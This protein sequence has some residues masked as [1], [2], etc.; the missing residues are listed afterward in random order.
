MRQAPVMTF[1]TALKILGQHEHPLLNK[2]DNLLGGLILAGGAVA[3]AGPAAAPVVAVA[4]AVWGWT[5]QKNEAVGLM[6]KLLAS[7]TRRRLG[8]SGYERAELLAAAHTILVASSAM[9]VFQEGLGQNSP[10]T[11]E[12]TKEE[13]HELLVAEFGHRVL[14]DLYDSGVP[15]PSGGSGFQENRHDVHEWLTILVNR[16]IDYYYRVDSLRGTGGW[17]Q[18]SA[19]ILRA[20]LTKSAEKRYESRYYELAAKIPEFAMWALLGRHD[21]HQAEL[22]DL[23]QEVLAALDG[24]SAALSRLEALLNV[25]AGDTNRAELELVHIVRRSALA[26]LDRPIVPHGTAAFAHHQKIVFPTLREIYIEPRYRWTRYGERSR[27][28]DEHWWQE[29]P[30]FADL[31]LRLAAYFASPDAARRPLLVLGH[32]GAGKSLLTKVLAARLPLV[33]FTAVRVPLRHVPAGAPIYLQVQEALNQ[34]THG[35]VAWHALTEQSAGTVRV[36]LLDGLDELLQAAEQSR[37]S[38]SRRGRRVPTRRGGT[39]AAGRGAGD[40]TDDRGRQ[41]RRAGGCERRQTRGIR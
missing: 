12:L 28:S 36:I 18:L 8:L 3:A 17:Q 24:Q 25:L 7:A 23:H 9:E 32:P 2:L 35:R 10:R 13:E 16:L 21:E 40:V 30:V 27:I 33:T 19:E 38:F 4:A 20:Q 29:L 26:E 31:G 6:R 15:F 22:R 14:D 1:R 41:G 39:T 5:E 34:A 37:S 11:L